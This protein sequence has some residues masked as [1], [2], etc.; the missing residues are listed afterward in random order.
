M[1]TQDV[2]IIIIPYII[3]N[4][5]NKLV[6]KLHGPRMYLLNAFFDNN[7]KMPHV[8]TNSINQGSE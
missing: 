2:G 5:S 6:H 7:F 1:F 3:I 4:Q 8:W